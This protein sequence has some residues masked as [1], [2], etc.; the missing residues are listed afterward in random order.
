MPD[1]FI[2]SL[3]KAKFSLTDMDVELSNHQEYFDNFW[4][5]G[6]Y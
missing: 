4:Q 2:N 6:V 1:F 5:A 3:T